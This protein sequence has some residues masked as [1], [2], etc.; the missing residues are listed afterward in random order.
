M[1]TVSS[2]S[3]LTRYGNSL[4]TKPALLYLDTQSLCHLSTFAHACGACGAC[5]VACCRCVLVV[6]VLVAHH[7]KPKLSILHWVFELAV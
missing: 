7:L 5:G 2:S 4:D 1:I 6:L 3:E